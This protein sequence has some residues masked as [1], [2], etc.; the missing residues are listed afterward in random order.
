M[1]MLD[2]AGIA[3]SCHGPPPHDPR[4]RQLSHKSSRRLGGSPTEAVTAQICRWESAST[5]RRS[6]HPR[7]TTRSLSNALKR[8]FPGSPDSDS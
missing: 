1:I 4:Q 2:R 8:W 5:R 7:P 6:T 3:P